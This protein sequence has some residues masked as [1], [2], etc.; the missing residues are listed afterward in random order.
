MVVAEGGLRGPPLQRRSPKVV[1]VMRVVA[2]CERLVQWLGLA[3]EAESECS[4]VR[5]LA[6]LLWLV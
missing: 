2:A 1:G 4:V 3:A 5:L 6:R